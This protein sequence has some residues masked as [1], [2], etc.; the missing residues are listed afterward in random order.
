MKT[1]ANE[2]R[3]IGEVLGTGEVHSRK[4]FAL[5]T[6]AVLLAAMTA[7]LVWYLATRDNATV[8]YRTAPITRSDLTVIVT[9]TGTVQPL[10]QVDV[11]TEISGTF[12]TVEVDYNDRVKVGQVLAR[13]DTEK[14]Q[15][16]VLQSEAAFESAKA[17]LSEAQATVSEVRITWSVSSRCANS[18]A[19]RYR[20]SE[21]TMR[22]TLYSSAL[23]R[24]RTRSRPRYPKLDGSSPSAVIR[25]PVNGIVLK[26]QV[27]PEQTVA[28]SLQT[29]VLFTIAENLAQMEVQVDV[30]RR[31][32][33]AK[34]RSA[35]RFAG[36][37]SAAVRNN[38]TCGS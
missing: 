17:K 19:G 8:Q 2:L 21:N 29:P 12:R 3:H 27:D 25:S 20:R 36:T 1:D 31:R 37:S 15:A 38:H 24:T 34:H 14:L 32:H 23:Y 28:A 33:T 9:A 35:E 10:N 26:R 16:Q 6:A 22:P 30:S 13:I 18:A 7:A 4:R 11:G 5:A